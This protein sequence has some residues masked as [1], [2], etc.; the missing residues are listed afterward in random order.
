MPPKHPQLNQRQRRS[1]S[2]GQHHDGPHGEWDSASKVRVGREI[3][4]GFDTNSRVKLRVTRIAYCLRHDRLAIFVHVG[5][6]EEVYESCHR[7]S[8]PSV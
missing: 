6:D 2:G 3:V 4:T 8:L 1:R 7:P 5:S